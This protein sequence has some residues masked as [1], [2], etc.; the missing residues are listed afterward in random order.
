MNYSTNQSIILTDG[1]GDYVDY[2]VYSNNHLLFA[3]RAYK[4]PDAQYLTIDVTD[5]CHSLVGPA[6][7]DSSTGHL[8]NAPVHANVRVQGN[9]NHTLDVYYYNSIDNTVPQSTYLACKPACHTLDP[10]QYLFIV[11]PGS[12]GMCYIYKNGS[13]AGSYST[14]TRVDLTPFALKTGDKL[15]LRGPDKS[16][17]YNVKCG[18]T[19]ILYYQNQIGGIDSVTCYGPTLIGSSTTRYSIAH[20]GSYSP[21]DM[22]FI[23][24]NKHNEGKI[25][26]KLTTG[27]LSDEDTENIYEVILSNKCWLHFPDTGKLYPVNITTSNIEQKTYKKDGMNTSYDITVEYARTVNSIN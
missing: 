5:I 27:P 8:N 6:E 21:G 4:Y 3:G 9:S 2:D 14:N 15:E 13:L 19:S 16:I 10:R 24:E 23:N 11:K 20:T 17:F 12:G 26:W 7:I 25:T 18:A 22:Q 1:T